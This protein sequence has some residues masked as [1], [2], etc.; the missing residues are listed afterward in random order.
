MLAGTILAEFF[1]A[2]HSH[3]L[4]KKNRL[5]IAEAK[6]RQA[7]DLL[8]I[9]HT[10]RAEIALNIIKI[11]FWRYFPFYLLVRQA[12]FFF[13]KVNLVGKNTESTCQFMSAEF[14]K[15]VLGFGH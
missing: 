10:D 14:Q 13:K 15:R 8:P 11:F 4:K 5:G 6:R 12:Q 2:F 9:F 7:L 3:S 1:N